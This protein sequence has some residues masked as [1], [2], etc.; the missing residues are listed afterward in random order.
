MNFKDLNNLEG[1]Q[2]MPVKENKQPIVKGWQTGIKKHNLDNCEAVGLVCGLP[3]GNLEAVDIDEKYSLDGKLFEKYKKLIHSADRNLLKKLVVQKTKS[4]GYHFIYRCS[5]ISGNLKLANRHT[6]EEERQATFNETYQGELANSKSDEDARKKAQKASDNDKIRVLFETRGLGGYIMCFPSKGY[7][8]IH[9]DF[10]SITEITSEERETLHGIARQFNEVIE[11]YS[12]PVKKTISKTDGLSPFDDYNV[13]GDVI[14]LLQEHGWKIVGRKGAK[15]IFLR[16]GQTSSH[17]SGN[18]DHDKNWFSVFTTST[19]FEPMRAYLPCYVFS[20]LE[21]GGDFSKAAKKL[22]ELG[23]GEKN[24]KQKEEKSSTRKIQSRIEVDNEDYSFLA[25]PEDYGDY[26]QQVRD[27]TL[28]MGLTTGSPQ[29]DEHFL[30]KEGNLVMI[31]GVDNVGKSV[32]IWWLMLVAA[33]NHGWRGII[34]SSENTLGAFMRKM[35]QFYWGLQLRGDYAMSDEQYKVAKYFVEKH[36]VLIKAQEDLYNYKDIINMVKKTCRKE[37]LNYAMV[38]PYNSLKIDLSGFSKL[39]TH[40]YHYEAL[41]EIKAFGQQNNF[42]WILNNH[43]V[44]SAARLKDADRRYPVAPRKEDTEGGQKFAN[45]A[46]DFLTIHRVTQHPT[47]WNI[48]EIHV[49]KIK[50]TETGGRPTP[51]DIPIK[52]EMIK[53]GSAFRERNELSA[54]NIDPIEE[55]HRKNGTMIERSIKSTQ[56]SL[57]FVKGG[58]P[59]YLPYKDE[60]GT[61]IEF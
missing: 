27:G 45:K 4:G 55:W 21:C 41:S 12:S 49:R 32:W 19:E 37:K 61:E 40:E 52:F 18:F 20:T 9:G 31:N 42:G 38:D 34:F 59:S 50:D 13:R 39:N 23:Y 30:L 51:L 58:T 36:F 28:K 35:I 26:L 48:T 25:T 6:T 1:L 44:T 14:A 15:T 57:S 16:P 17:S 46:D 24:E 60:N 43:A 33:M 7:E 56:D 22:I 11:E 47:D 2:F 5:T 3:S 8:L 53:G 29:L 54:F 10:Y